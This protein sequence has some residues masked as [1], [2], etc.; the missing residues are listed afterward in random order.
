MS[1]EDAMTRMIGRLQ[2]QH[3][4]GHSAEHAGVAEALA[5]LPSPDSVSDPRAQLA[6]ATARMIARQCGVEKAQ[7]AIEYAE[8]LTAAA[9]A[10]RFDAAANARMV[11]TMRRANQARD[12][13]AE[14]DALLQVARETKSRGPSTPRVGGSSPR[15]LAAVLAAARR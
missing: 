1:L 6:I 4:A 11:E 10:F 5:R 7:A 3:S 8:Q 15:G 12:D 2:P 14:L 9:P 13:A